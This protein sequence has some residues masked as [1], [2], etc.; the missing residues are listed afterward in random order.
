[1]L[2]VVTTQYRWL[3][4]YN[5]VTVGSRLLLFRFHTCPMLY[6]RGWSDVDTILGDIRDIYEVQ[7]Q[8]EDILHFHPSYYF[9]VLSVIRNTKFATNLYKAV[10]SYIL[11]KVFLTS[12]YKALA[13]DEDLLTCQMMKQDQVTARLFP[14][15][16]C[17][18]VKAWWW[19]QGKFFHLG[20]LNEK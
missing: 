2:S 15:T 6:C 5:N 8:G 7:E 3:Y 4:V 11:R 9:N 14:N 18:R 12:P 1:M 13:F 19:Y 17:V 10:P 16:D 20:K